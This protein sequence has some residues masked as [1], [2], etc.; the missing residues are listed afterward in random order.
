M[1]I[2]AD[3]EV[4]KDIRMKQG[5]SQRKLAVKAGIN[6]STISRI[7][8]GGSIPSRLIAY[9]ICTALGKDFCELFK[10]NKGVV[11]A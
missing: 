1:T 2:K 9:K 10:D 5:W 4:L 8:N 6:H 7:E 11:L 3:V